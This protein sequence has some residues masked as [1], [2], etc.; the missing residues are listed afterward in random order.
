M[1]DVRDGMLTLADKPG[2]GFEPD[3]AALEPFQRPIH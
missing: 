2:F 1:P 3:F